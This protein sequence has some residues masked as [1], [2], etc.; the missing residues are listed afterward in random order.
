MLAQLSAAAF[1]LFAT[2]G[3][4]VSQVSVM[5]DLSS[6][7]FTPLTA[8]LASVVPAVLPVIVTCCGFRKGINF[9]MSAIRGA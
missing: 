4:T 7:D 8:T 3:E 9:M 5:L 2:A 1:T 6:V